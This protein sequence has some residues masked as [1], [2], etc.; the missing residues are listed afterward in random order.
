M[1]DLIIKQNDKGYVL[2]LTWLNADGTAKDLSGGGTVNLKAWKKGLP[3]TLIA[4][5]AC[6]ITS[7][8]TAG[9]LTCTIS[10]LTFTSNQL[11]EMELEQSIGGTVVDSS[12]TYQLLVEESG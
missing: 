4:N 10:A 3:G 8:A 12:N 9:H 2:S 6:S 5:I 11:L 1:A 7:P